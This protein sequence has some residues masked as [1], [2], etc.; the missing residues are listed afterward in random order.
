[1][2]TE[3]LSFLIYNISWSKTANSFYQTLFHSIP[4]PR[5][6]FPSSIITNLEFRPP[7]CEVNQSKSLQQLHRICGRQLGLPSNR[8]GT[9]LTMGKLRRIQTNAITAS[10]ILLSVSSTFPL[11]RWV[12]H[13]RSQPAHKYLQDKQKP[14]CLSPKRRHLRTILPNLAH[15]SLRALYLN[16]GDPQRTP[17]FGLS[18]ASSV[19][20]FD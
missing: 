13:L 2:E 4:T 17:S 9:I 5:L 16:L 14:D 15:R 11:M 1:M 10:S 8:Q 7:S 19:I 3:P 6:Q 18:L 20:S 12:I